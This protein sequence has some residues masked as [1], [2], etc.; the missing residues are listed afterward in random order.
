MFQKAVTKGWSASDSARALVNLG[1]ERVEVI[2]AVVGQIRCRE[3]RPDIFHGV[4]LWRVRRKTFHMQPMSLFGEESF[5][6]F[7]SMGGKP[8]PQ[9]HHAAG[10]VSAQGAKKRFD[11]GTL[12]TVLM[13]GKEK[14][15]VPPCG[16]CGE[17][18]D[19][20]EPFPCEGMEEG[21]GFPPRRPCA[22]DGGT[23]R[24]SRFVL[25][26]DGGALTAGFFL[27]DGHVSLTQRSMAASSRSLARRSG[28]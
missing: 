3:M 15:H 22:A 12:D 19:Q 8:I 6:F 23:L 28:F 24:K 17:G 21:R 26:D 16:R 2:S 4:E 18:A 5:R 20:G 11:H 9:E 27:I 1:A 25:K 7:A 13:D 14:P 10:D